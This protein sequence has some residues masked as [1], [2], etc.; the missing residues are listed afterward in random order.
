MRR[1]DLALLAAASLVLPRAAGAQ[2]AERVHV[3]GYLTGATGSPE[4]LFGV[5]QTRA[6]VS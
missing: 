5:L 4:D 2:P 1:R 3:I 6:L